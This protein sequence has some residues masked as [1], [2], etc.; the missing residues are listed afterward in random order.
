ME[1]PGKVKCPKCEEIVDRV[2]GEYA[3][4]YLIANVMCTASKR[5]I[6]ETKD[7]NHS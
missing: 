4:H 3:L 6:Q 1:T 2:D 7:D 5:E